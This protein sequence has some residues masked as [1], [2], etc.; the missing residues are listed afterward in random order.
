MPD[1]Y[2]RNS[3]TKKG[4]NLLAESIAT[5]K[6]ITF[7]K[8]VVGDGDDTGLDINTM[9]G[10]VSPKMELPIG[11]GEKGGDGE[12]V[13]Q[14]VLSNKTLEHSFFPKEVGL[15]AK[16]GDGEEVLYSYSNGGNNVGLMPDKNTPINAEIYNIRTKIGNA[17]NITFVASDDTYITKG[18][19]T[20]HNADANAH[21]NRF[22]A[23]IQQVN[24][25]ITSVDNSDSLAKAPTLQ[26]V[27][28]LLSSLNIKNATDVV[29]A[30]ESEKT[31]GLG[32]RY[33]FSNVNAWYICLGK[34]FGNLIIQ[35]GKVNITVGRN[36]YNDDTVYPIAFN[37]LPS[38]NII[39]I[40]DTLDQDGW[41]TSAIKS[42]T[43]LKF[44]YI[45]AQNS[46]TGISWIAIGN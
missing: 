12:Y 20:K 18:E 14:A 40:A 11:N 10:V 13:I 46:V 17:T 3:V 24:N 38:V 27:K 7:T 36:I 29:N 26:L 9:T 42:I 19:L 2:N 45:T 6:P 4:Y 28:T 41:V 33:D 15:F 5:K 8:V 34:L 35:G 39:N 43:N 44:T 32:I 16:C 37:N 22:N 25:M 21:D 23:I 1:V 31:T 30:L